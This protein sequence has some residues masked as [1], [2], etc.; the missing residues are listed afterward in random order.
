MAT[1]VPTT[2]NQH[3]VQGNLLSESGLP[4]TGITIRLYNVGF[5]GQDTKVAETQSD[6]LGNYTFAYQLPPGQSP[7][8]Q[9]RAVDAEG[10]EVP[11]S[12]TK[13]GATSQETLNLVVAGSLQPLAPEY[14]RLAADIGKQIGSIA[15]LGQAQE[16][17]DRQDITLVS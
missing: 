8:I 11:I 2:L 6:S 13:L 15:Q 7:N 4:A 5:A 3:S 17:S 9:V 1:I 12:T 16:G 10:K 14:T